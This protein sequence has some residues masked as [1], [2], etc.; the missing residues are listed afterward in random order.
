MRMIKEFRAI[1][2]GRVQMVMY[3]DF[4][5]RHAKKHRVV[6]TVK[7]L[8]D[9]TV[10]VIAQGEE[11]DLHAYLKKLHRGPILARVREVQVAWREPSSEF[12]GFNITY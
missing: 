2:S 1:V 10:E 7:N 12:G 5:Q 4:A 11:Q 6:G 9:G 8:P 3:R